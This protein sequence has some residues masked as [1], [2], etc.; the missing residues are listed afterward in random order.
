L[1]IFA[2]L[3][4]QDTGNSFSPGGL[5][6]NFLT[7]HAPRLYCYL[8]TPRLLWANVVMDALIAAS[9][10]VIFLCL[11]WISGRLHGQPKFAPYLWVSLSFGLFIVACGGTHLMDVVDL[12]W[13]S[14]KLATGIR[15]LCA[16]ASVPTAILFARAIPKI[17]WDIRRYVEMLAHAQLQRDLAQSALTAAE[18]V[19]VERGEAAEGTARVNRQLNSVMNSTT[20]LILQVG[21]DWKILYGNQEAEK[22]LPDFRVGADFWRCFPG[23]KGTEAEQ[24]F[25]TGMRTHEEQQ[26]SNYYEPYSKWYRVHIFSAGSGISIFV[27]DITLE[28]TLEESLA[29]ERFLREK[30]VEQLSHMA[31][32]LAH[33]I[34]NPLAIIHARACDLEELTAGGATPSAE[35]VQKAC[36]NIVLTAER[37]TRILR[38]L[39][40]L[41]R[42]ASND[43]MELADIGETCRLCVEMQSS[44]LQ[45][46]HIEMRLELP[47]YLP[48]V[49]CREAQIGQI[50]SNL[51]SNGFDAIVLSGANGGW[52]SLEVERRGGDLCIRVSDSGPEIP[53]EIRD[54]LMEPFFTTKPMGLGTGVGL[55]LS[56][57]IASDHGGSLTL[58]EGTSYT[59]FELLLPVPATE[60][61]TSQ[62]PEA[63][64]A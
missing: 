18:E 53:E 64:A 2:I 52:I 20:E 45:R 22:T 60:D 17:E 54:K 63:L 42:E 23:L 49:L 15:I 46:Y 24:H 29:Q 51:L 47:E 55:S 62:E 30:H 9:Y 27:H 39:K 41:A 38:G 8:E 6:S 26:F 33:E 3:S 19:A 4:F 57:A 43:P 12:W 36:R 40:G 37:A 28:K 1:T 7:K 31:A 32:G 58:L 48:K 5:V 21:P 34:S 59:S 13:P 25:L 16:A 50:V 14:L 35:T 44:R 61:A 11:L 10:A 56:R